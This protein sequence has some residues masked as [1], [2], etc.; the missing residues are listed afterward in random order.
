MN[1]AV[2]Y[3]KTCETVK[4]KRNKIEN[5]L[6]NRKPDLKLRNFLELEAI[7]QERPVVHP[8]SKPYLIGFFS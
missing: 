5:T 7:S 1:P 2:K 3:F 8:S 4:V 6:F